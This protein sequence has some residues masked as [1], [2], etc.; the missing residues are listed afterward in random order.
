MN[1]TPDSRPLCIGLTGNMGSGKSTVARWFVQWGAFVFDSDQV[2]K[3]LYLDA[4]VKKEV[5]SLLGNHAYHTDGTINRTYIAEK[6]F[7]NNELLKR[8]NSIIHP[9]VRQLREVS[10]VQAAQ[11]GNK[12]WVQEAALLFESGA[13][14]GLD[15][16]IVVMA[17]I[18]MRTQWLMESRKLSLAEI[19]NR[20]SH[21]WDL[22]TMMKYKPRV[23]TNDST[24]EDLEA[25]AKELWLDLL[26]KC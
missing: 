25:K 22:H 5:I 1:K 3:E 21:Q 12:I 18:E 17:P 2:A 11:N 16:C 6:V 8:I 23:I 10:I 20:T 24:L 19:H 14:E 26:K 15:A 13:N 4:S 9:R 7:S